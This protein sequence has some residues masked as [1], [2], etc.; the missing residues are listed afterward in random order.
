MTISTSRLGR[1]QPVQQQLSEGQEDD[2][3]DPKTGQEAASTAATITGKD[4]QTARNED[5]KR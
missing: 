1:K 4:S 5:M 3:S 2:H